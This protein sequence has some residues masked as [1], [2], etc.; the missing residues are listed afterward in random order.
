MRINQQDIRL[1]PLF[2]THAGFAWCGLTRCTTFQLQQGYQLCN[3][4]LNVCPCLKSVMFGYKHFNHYGEQSFQAVEN[5]WMGGCIITFIKWWS[6]LLIVIFPSHTTAGK[7]CGYL[8]EVRNSKLFARLQLASQ[9][10][11]KPKLQWV[12]GNKYERKADLKFQ[13]QGGQTLTSD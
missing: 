12:Y 4:P 8:A 10:V 6:Y 1:G 3:V 5:R 11:V 7:K 13:S 9:W 2:H